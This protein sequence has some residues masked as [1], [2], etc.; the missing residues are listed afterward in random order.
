MK[1]VFIY[2]A[3]GVGK[4]TTARALA[5]LTGFRVFHNHLSFNLVKSVFDFPSTAF[6]ELAGTIRVATLQAAARARLPGLIFTFVYA[7]PD[8]DRFVR[9]I[10]EAVEQHGGEVLFVRLTCDAATHERRVVGA[11]RSTLGKLASVESLRGALARWNLTTAIPD[12][13]GLEID[14]STQSPA[15]VAQRIAAQF[16]LPVM[17]RQGGARA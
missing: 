2:G 7:A 1:L 3:P 4:L 12:R 16:G 15:V 10:V 9:Q 11:E 13:P 17:G 5:E 8:D 14:N 6:W